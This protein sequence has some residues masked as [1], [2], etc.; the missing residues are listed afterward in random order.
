MHQQ[1]I[2]IVD[3]NAEPSPMDVAFDI[4]FSVG[5]RS[6]SVSRSPEHST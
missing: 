4:C 3:V 1:A 2:A 6:D 5:Y